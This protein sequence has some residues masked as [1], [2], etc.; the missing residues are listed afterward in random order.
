MLCFWL[1]LNDIPLYEI[2]H[3]FVHG[4]LGISHFFYIFNSAAL[5]IFAVCVNLGFH[6]SWVYA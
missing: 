6:F 4:H 2:Q 5:N 1:L 3:L